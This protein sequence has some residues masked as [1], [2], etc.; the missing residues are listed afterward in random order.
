MPPYFV[1]IIVVP[2][3]LSEPDKRISHTSGSSVSHSVAD[4]QV[5]HIADVVIEAGK[6]QRRFPARLFSYPCQVSCHRFSVPC[7]TSMFPLPRPTSRGDLRSAGVSRFIARPLRHTGPHHSRRGHPPP[8]FYI[9]RSTRVLPL[10]SIPQGL[11]ARRSPGY[12]PTVTRLDAV[13]DPGVTASCLSLSH[14]PHGLRP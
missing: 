5:I 7:I 4:S 13:L 12:L 11:L 10:R 14:S 1:H 9:G 8:S 2:L 3:P 6:H